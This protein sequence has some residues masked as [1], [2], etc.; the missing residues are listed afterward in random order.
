MCNTSRRYVALLARC[1]TALRLQIKK[2]EVQC[3]GLCVMCSYWFDFMFCFRF[4][5]IFLCYSLDNVTNPSQHHPVWDCRRPFRALILAFLYNSMSAWT[6]GGASSS[7]TLT[8][9]VSA[10]QHWPLLWTSFLICETITSHTSETVYLTPQKHLDTRNNTSYKSDWSTFSQNSQKWTLFKWLLMWHL[11]QI[12][13][14]NW[15]HTG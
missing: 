8:L 6:W 3:F 12:T 5:S 11:N 4:M 14:I 15:T 2:A 1:V 7:D 9:P 13:I 10:L